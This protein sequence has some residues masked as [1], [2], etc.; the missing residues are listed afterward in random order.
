MSPS[1]HPPGSPILDG[2]R[3]AGG[4]PQALTSPSRLGRFGNTR[5][6]LHHCSWTSSLPTR[7]VTCTK[8][9]NRMR[10]SYSTKQVYRMFIFLQ[11]WIGKIFLLCLYNPECWTQTNRLFKAFPGY[12]FSAYTR[13]D[14]SF[15]L[16]S[17]YT[18][19]SSLLVSF[20]KRLTN[21]SFL[22]Q[23]RVADRTTYSI[24]QLGP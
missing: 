10:G 22:I 5:W 9:Y 1:C 13:S 17:F 24:H 4:W 14:S 21:F 11:E 23:N 7:P 12:A 2:S 16:S 3:N 15:S 18:F 20:P 19:D 6:L 8:L